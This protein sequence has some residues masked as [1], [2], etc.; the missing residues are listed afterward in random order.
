MS[1]NFAQRLAGFLFFRSFF[2]LIKVHPLYRRILHGGVPFKRPNKYA[3]ASS[4]IITGFSVAFQWIC[5]TA[6]KRK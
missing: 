4:G 6:A 2:G 5:E 3:G 1:R